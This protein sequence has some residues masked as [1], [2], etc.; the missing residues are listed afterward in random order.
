MALPNRHQCL[1]ECARKPQDTCSAF[2]PTSRHLPA[3]RA[4]AGRRARRPTSLGSSPT[5][6]RTSKGS[7]TKRRIPRRVTRPA[8]PCSSLLS[9]PFS[10]C[11]RASAPRSCFA[12]CSVGPP[13][14]Q[15]RCSAA[16]PPRSTALCSGRAKRSPSAILTAVRC[17][18]RPIPRS[19]SFL[20][21]IYR[22]GKGMISMVSWPC[23]K[24]TRPSPCR[25][26][27]SGMWAR[28]YR[29]VLCDGLEDLWRPSPAADGSQRPAGFRRLCASRRRR[30]RRPRTPSTCSRSSVT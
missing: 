20:A 1:P 23:S 21:A 29:V 15:R 26:G 22:P 2:C 3:H 6:T 18:S 14:K 5:R 30:R 27:C 11:R 8:K 13:L 7:P 17:A 12:M 25:R 19:K 24:K 4:D 9:P 10:S 16:P 28:G